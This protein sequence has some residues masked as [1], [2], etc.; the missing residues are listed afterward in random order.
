MVIV[1]REDIRHFYRGLD[2]VSHYHLTEQLVLDHRRVIY[3]R[4]IQDPPP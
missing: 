2:T 1:V 3:D 4:N